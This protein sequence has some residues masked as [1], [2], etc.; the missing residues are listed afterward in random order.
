MFVLLTYT[1]DFIVYFVS[2]LRA[3]LFIKKIIIIIIII[4]YGEEL[5]VLCPTP[6]L[7]DQPLS[8]VLDCL[9]KTFAATLHIGGRSSIRNMRTRHAVATGNHLSWQLLSL[10][11]TIESILGNACSRSSYKCTQV[12]LTS[13][14]YFIRF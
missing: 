1:S 2:A 9:F 13:P 5:L 10:S 14:C 7:E 11:I 6:K 3:G 4:I 8:P 12:F